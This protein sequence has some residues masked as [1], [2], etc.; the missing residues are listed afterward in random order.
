MEKKMTSLMMAVLIMANSLFA[1]DGPPQPE[2]ITLTIILDTSWS[3]EHEM[4][5]Y[6]SLTRQMIASLRPGDYLEIITGHPGKPKLRFAQFIKSGN[7]REIGSI[8]A[9]LKGIKSTHIASTIRGT[10]ALPQ[11]ESR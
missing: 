10:K 5:D 2:P 4:S 1:L 11:A 7:A 6:R 8:I 3:N 9:L